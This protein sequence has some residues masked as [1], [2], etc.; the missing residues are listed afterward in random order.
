MKFPPWHENSAPKEHFIM[1]LNDFPNFSGKLE[2]IDAISSHSN[3]ILILGI[4][5]IWIVAHPGWPLDSHQKVY[6]NSGLHE[7]VWIIVDDGQNNG[8]GRY[9]IPRYETK[10][11]KNSYSIL[12]PSW[13]RLQ[14]KKISK[15]QQEQLNKEKI[16][17][18]TQVVN[19][20]SDVSWTELIN[21]LPPNGKFLR[22]TDKYGWRVPIFCKNI[23]IDLG[24]PSRHV[25][26]IFSW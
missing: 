21:G 3:T 24:T 26:R 23:R 1:Q 6:A 4:L 8:P 25:M 19:I 9:I 22:E 10:W 17:I 18:L 12:V 13:I 5:D 11:M 20:S 15:Q 14:T 16:L 2:A 7:S